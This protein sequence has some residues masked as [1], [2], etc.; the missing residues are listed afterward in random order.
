MRSKVRPVFVIA[1]PVRD[2]VEGL[3]GADPELSVF[4]DSVYTFKVRAVNKSTGHGEWS[5]PAQI[6]TAYQHVKVSLLTFP[7][8]VLCLLLRG[9]LKC[10]SHSHRPHSD[11]TEP[12]PC[13]VE[14]GMLLTPVP[15]LQ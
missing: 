15:T 11:R 1:D 13:R 10:G 5:E 12:P 3:L 14:C 9:K 4:V 2:M 6:G 7:P 8:M